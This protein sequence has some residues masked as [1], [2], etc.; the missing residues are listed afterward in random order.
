MAKVIIELDTEDGS[1]TATI[2]GKAV[3]DVE[4]I[5]ISRYNDDYKNKPEIG[6]SISTKTINDDG[7]RTYTNICAEHSK[8]GRTALALGTLKTEFDDFVVNP[9]PAEN[10]DNPY[11]DAKQTV[12]KQ[13]SKIFGKKG[14]E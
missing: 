3:N 12:A 1:L 4:S 2:N 11:V 8:S 7:V 5:M 13:F 9:V 14:R 6:C 10:K